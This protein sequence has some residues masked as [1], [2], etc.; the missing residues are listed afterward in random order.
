MLQKEETDARL[1]FGHRII[2]AEDTLETVRVGV[3]FP[4]ERIWREHRTE[5]NEEEAEC[6]KREC[7]ETQEENH[8][9][10]AETQEE[11]HRV[12]AMV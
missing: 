5:G 9:V 10:V 4:V 6:W 1:E 8:R 3:G 12:V 11:K 2:C 7:S